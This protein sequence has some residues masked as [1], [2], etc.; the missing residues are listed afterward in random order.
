MLQ[1][2]I[3]KCS[4]A[5]V[6]LTL[7]PVSKAVKRQNL[8]YLSALKLKS[9]ER[10]LDRIARENVPGDLL[11]FGL[12]LGGSGIVISRL[13]RRGS[14]AR[15]FH[16]FDVF[17]MIPPPSSE[18]DDSKSR[19]RYDV[20]RSGKSEGLGGN[21]YYGYRS[22][23]F[24]DVQNSF[25]SFAEPIDM[26]SRSLHKG[27]FA[28]TWPQIANKIERVAFAHIDCDW[29]DP[30]LYCLDAIKDKMAIGGSIILDD[31]HDYS[32]CRK[33]TDEFLAREPQFRIAEDN[34]NLVLHRV[35]GI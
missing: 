33:A 9:I 10:E 8:T 30:V 20:I 21:E 28:D 14:S 4:K 35:P 3:R 29:Y 18:N 12:A 26:S 19:E 17:A 7:S 5:I 32:G 27:L 1:R 25:K 6:G 31:Y 16:G 11:E 22:D 34:E 23:L 24:T 13:G 15:S 2:V